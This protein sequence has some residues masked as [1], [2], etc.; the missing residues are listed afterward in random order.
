MPGPKSQGGIGRQ[1]CRLNNRVGHR[2]RKLKL[3]CTIDTI[4]P[5]STFYVET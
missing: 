1:S 3:K 5:D 2:I 4:T